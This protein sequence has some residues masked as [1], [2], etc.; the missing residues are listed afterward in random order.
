MNERPVSSSGKIRDFAD[1]GTKVQSCVRLQSV[2]LS[3]M[4]YVS[5][6]KS[7][8]TVLYARDLEE[9]DEAAQRRAL[10][11]YRQ[12]GGG[13]SAEKTALQSSRV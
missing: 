3:Y 10:A 13:E 5:L 11:L 12:A 4:S 7:W 1:F 2:D 8:R 6:D 9:G